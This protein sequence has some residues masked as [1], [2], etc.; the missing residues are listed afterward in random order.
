MDRNKQYKLY[1]D[2]M[3]YK[4]TNDLVYALN[5]LLT[6]LLQYRKY[7]NRIDI[8]ENYNSDD[9]SY[10]IGTYKF[11]NNYIVKIMNNITE[12]NTT[13]YSPYDTDLFYRSDLS[14][15]YLQLLQLSSPITTSQSVYQSTPQSVPQ[16][17]S[18]VVS[19]SV[20]QVASQVVS[21]SVPQV[22][23]QVASQSVPPVSSVKTPSKPSKTNI[24]DILT[25][26]KNIAESLCAQVNHN[27]K[28]FEGFSKDN[29]S[30]LN[31]DLSEH[32]SISDSDNDNELNQDIELL[33][34]EL[35]GLLLKKE[36]IDKNLDK[37]KD[38]LSDLHCEES[39]NK[40]LER[41][42]QDLIKEKKNI[43][44]SDIS[45][46]YRLKDKINKLP[47]T[48]NKLE[49]IPEL[50]EA[51]YFVLKF[52][53]SEAYL[54]DEDLKSPSDEIFELYLML[55]NTF[56]EDYILDES[57]KD[58]I[59]AFTETLPEKSIVTSKQIMDKLNSN[60][61]NENNRLFE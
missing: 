13:T 15:M 28:C 44:I 33:E 40:L 48:E 34:K 32:D 6:S 26:S 58:L 50:F 53:D 55:L 16:V 61:H 8:Y 52:L 49:Y 59:E 20:P 51:K 24:S 45:V 19:Q 3:H 14:Q 56:E 36:I 38:K 22:A 11:I 46:Y 9:E 43:F 4:T 25:E 31:N 18:Q 5:W 23:S 57:Y 35:D 27:D 37:E 12:H 30:L 7:T 41:K 2:T 17:A 10:Y 1:N 29:L 39:Y 60:P 21:Q 47:S 54:Q 42:K